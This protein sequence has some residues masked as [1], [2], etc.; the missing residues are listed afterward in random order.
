MTFLSDNRYFS[1]PLPSSKCVHQISY[2]TRIR[3]TDRTIFRRRRDFDRVSKTYT[4]RTRETKGEISRR[5]NAAGIDNKTVGTVR[6][7][8]RERTYITADKYYAIEFFYVLKVSTVRF[9]FE[10]YTHWRARERVGTTSRRALQVGQ[11]SSLPSE[12]ATSG[13]PVL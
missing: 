4:F 13:Q 9:R 2:T 10:T 11:R 6:P 7:Q 5:T 1:A 3:G 12:A 8:R